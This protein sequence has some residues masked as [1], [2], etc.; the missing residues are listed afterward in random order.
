MLLKSTTP[1]NKSGMNNSFSVIFME[2]N[3]AKTEIIKIFTRNNDLINRKCGITRIFIAKDYSIIRK[4]SI[5]KF[6]ITLLVT[7]QSVTNFN[8]G[9]KESAALSHVCWVLQ[10]SR[11]Y[12]SIKRFSENSFINTFIVSYIYQGKIFRNS[13][14]PHFLNLILI[15]NRIKYK[16]T[17]SN[18]FN[19]HLLSLIAFRNELYCRWISVTTALLHILLV[20][21]QQG[22]N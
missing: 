14:I 19:T 11:Q 2:I 6:L 1:S 15:M 8:V 22:K 4:Y 9:R 17:S 12:F 21:Q 18:S 16:G 13:F 7:N 20:L 3:I 5:I 10:L